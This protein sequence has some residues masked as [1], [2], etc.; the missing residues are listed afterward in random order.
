MATVLRMSDYR[1]VFVLPEGAG[2]VVFLASRG[3]CPRI[4]HERTFTSRPDA[5]A[6]AGKLAT[7]FGCRTIGADAVPSGPGHMANG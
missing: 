2:T 4:A 5:L 6:Y 7:T 1:A 3:P